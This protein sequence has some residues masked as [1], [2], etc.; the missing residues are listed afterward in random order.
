MKHALLACLS[1]TLL[2]HAFHVSAQEQLSLDEYF[3]GTGID[4]NAAPRS[5]DQPIMPPPTSPSRLLPAPP[6]STL[7]RPAES[8]PTRS[9]PQP[10]PQPQPQR[11][12]LDLSQID[13]LTGLPRHMTSLGMAPTSTTSAALPETS[14]AA[15]FTTGTSRR[16]VSLGDPFLRTSGAIA[17][18]PV[19][20]S[21]TPAISPWP[22]LITAPQAFVP[23]P[24]VRVAQGPIIL[25]GRIEPI[26]V[27]VVPPLPNSIDRF[28]SNGFV[29]VTAPE[30]REIFGHEHDRPVAT[31]AERDPDWISEVT[32]PPYDRSMDDL[33]ISRKGFVA[34]D[35]W[36]LHAS[37]LAGKGDDLGI[38]SVSGNMTFGFPQWD[39]FTVR[40]SFGYHALSGPQ[41]TDLP[42]SLHDLQIEAGWRQT[43]NERLNLRVAVT[44]GLYSGFEQSSLS[45]AV[46]VS[47]LALMAYEAS[48]DLQLVLGAAYLNLE[49]ISALPI[50]GIVYHPDDDTRLE[51][52]FPEAKLAWRVSQTEAQD[53]WAYLGT[54]FFGRTWHIG[55]AT[56]REEDVTYTDWRVA[57]GLETKLV[58]HLSWYVELGGAFNRELTYESHVGDY[59]PG[60]TGF[61]RGGIYY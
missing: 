25:E 23:P 11:P 14:F 29:D 9:Q 48:P 59:D 39:N 3:R 36:G 28:A 4:L 27:S 43:V 20:A 40:P 58:H 30:P 21:P 41:S 34:L 13:P 35:H 47:G 49:T 24:A 10:Q 1:L 7:A 16:P 55:R 44:T 8:F 17:A 15:P 32:N 33:C 2:A 31:A 56:G 45:G 19:V 18:P 50:V 61:L 37:Y 53:R 46:R 60:T 54:Q 5:V 12:K 52:L 57:L 51:L 26:D 42:S 22:T 6:A 38:A